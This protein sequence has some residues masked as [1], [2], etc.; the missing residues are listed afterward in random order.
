M[1]AKKQS[2]QESARTAQEVL[3]EIVAG[4]RR[5]AERAGADFACL[6]E[7][8]NP[9]T[10]PVATLTNADG[11]PVGA[12]GEEAQPGGELTLRID[13]VLD[14]F[15]GVNVKALV[16]KIDEAKPSAIKVVISSPGGSLRDGLYLFN[17]LRAQARDNK[18]KI[19][20]EVYSIA[21]SAATF[22]LLAGDERIVHV[23]GSVMI[24]QPTMLVIGYGNADE[25]AEQGKKDVS[26]LK[27]AE[28]SMR[29]V[30]VNRTKLTAKQVDDA[31][32][33][34]TWYQPEEALETGFATMEAPD[35]AEQPE[36]AD[37]GDGADNA[38]PEDVANARELLGL[39]RKAVN[40]ET[41]NGEAR[42][43]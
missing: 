43:A 6:A 23:G 14:E 1:T 24:H 39:L 19:C 11:S 10:D 40:M 17:E 4:Y 2:G 13:G 36:N 7:G 20:S 21:A 30:Y 31:V 28:K 33:E 22:P 16:R 27:N 8:W 34:E 41:A 25:L 37:A 15:Y 35:D 9:E 32:A 3:A 29:S 42:Q 12:N 26:M 5:T 38:R 18:V